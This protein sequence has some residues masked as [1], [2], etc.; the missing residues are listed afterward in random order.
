M[1]PRTSFV[2]RRRKRYGEYR[3]SDTLL[4]ELGGS[5]VEGFD[6]AFYQVKTSYPDLDLSH[7]N[8]NIQD[9][10]SVQPVHSK[11]T[12]ELFVDD[13]LVDDPHCDRGNVVES[14]IKFVVDNTRHFDV[15]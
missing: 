13:A 9:Q 10:T 7:A 2:R 11:S 12:D 5:F 15:V 6:D 4:A 8:I 1:T 14:Q 3:D